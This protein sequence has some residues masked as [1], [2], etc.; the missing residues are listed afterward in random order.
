VGIQLHRHAAALPLLLAGCHLI[1]PFE[2]ATPS[3]D[4]AS[5]DAGEA[6]DA[7]VSRFD[8]ARDNGGDGSV[9]HDGGGQGDA[10]PRTCS[11]PTM[12]GAFLQQQASGALGGDASDTG[13]LLYLKYDPV[14]Y[15]PGCQPAQ[16]GE[17][18]QHAD[19]V[20]G[21]YVL[22]E[23]N[24]PDFAA[25][26]G[27]L[28]NGVNETLVVCVGVPSG[29]AGCSSDYE[30]DLLGTDLSGF[31]IAEIR[32]VTSSVSVKFNAKQDNVG[33]SFAAQWQ[34]WGCPP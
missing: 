7:T 28:T 12:I 16:V 20:T 9:G 27:C 34:V 2:L 18:L 13:L 23:D 30:A 29:A 25:F 3:G 8:Q 15:P 17:A 4:G 5:P 33:V 19:G 14:N 21:T 26:A 1:F 32:L 10:V 31:L 6:V 24:E 22:D 11:T